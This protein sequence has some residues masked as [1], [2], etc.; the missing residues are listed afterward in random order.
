MS[1]PKVASAAAALRRSVFAAACLLLSGCGGLF[2]FDFGAGDFLPELGFGGACESR[3]RNAGADFRPIPDIREG[4]C[5]VDQAVELYAASVPLDQPATLSCPTALALLQWERNVMQPLAE[6]HLGSRVVEIDQF[7]SYSCRGR[8]SD[9]S[10]LSEHAFGNA[11]DIGVFTLADGRRVSV[12]EWYDGGQEST[13]LRQV[14]RGACDMFAV[15]LTPI[16]DAAHY[17]H[18]HLDLSDWPLCEA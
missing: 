15:V 9:P 6:R 14:A 12:T 2:D 17:N 1:A 8:S 7:A 11:I 3:L 18:F 4:S 13:F 5:R 16:S 10:R